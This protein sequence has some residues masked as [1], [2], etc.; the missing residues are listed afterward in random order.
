MTA[1]DK[2]GPNEILD[3]MGKGCEAA[4]VPPFTVV[5]NWQAGLKK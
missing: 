4:A 1:G 3:L 5:T 2:L